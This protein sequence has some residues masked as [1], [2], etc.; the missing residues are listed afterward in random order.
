[1]KKRRSTMPMK[2]P[3]NFS[4]PVLSL[5]ACL[6]GVSSAQAIPSWAESYGVGN[7]IGDKVTDD[8]FYGSGFDFPVAMAKMPDGGFVVAGRL[9]L[10]EF[11]PVGYHTSDRAM[12]TL[13]RF[14]AD[15]TI[16]W[17][18]LVRQ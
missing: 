3:Q 17:Q 14:A 10:P 11:Y 18:R 8:P 5:I 4:L 1:M 7:Y 15:G 12:G 9:D 13:V 6:A 2:L 16:L